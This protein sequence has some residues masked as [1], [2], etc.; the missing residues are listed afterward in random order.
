[1]TQ[2]MGKNKGKLNSLFSYLEKQEKSE[3]FF[4]EKYWTL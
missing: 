4:R 2:P 1:M 3:G